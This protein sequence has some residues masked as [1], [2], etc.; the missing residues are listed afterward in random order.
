[1][2][3]FVRRFAI[4]RL[5]LPLA[6]AVF[7]P[8]SFA[9]SLPVGAV[10]LF[11]S[12]QCP[13]GWAPLLSADGYFFLP[14]MEGGHNMSRSGEALN[15]G[16]DPQHKHMIASSINIE[17]TQFVAIGGCCN[18]SLA[19]AGTKSFSTPADAVSPGLPYVTLLACTK[20]DPPDT[21]P[22][23]PQHTLM[24]FST[25]S[26]PSGW[27]KNLFTQGRFPVGLPA[28][29]TPGLTFGG[30][31]LAPLERRTHTHAFSGEVATEKRDVAIGSGCCTGGYAKN[32]T[33]PYTGVSSA[34][35]SGL[36]YMQ[37]LQCEK[38]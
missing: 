14:L 38:N 1:M 28:N 8:P 26:C 6:L 13:T 21:S 9:D 5:L 15:P 10:S 12:I 24:Y 23:P 11:N 34:D 22:P 36:P 7:A 29:G 27:T 18:D 35:D 20:R 19:S 31:P 16:A 25:P 37:L 3:T 33:Y 2:S 4:R 30:A 17:G 32:G